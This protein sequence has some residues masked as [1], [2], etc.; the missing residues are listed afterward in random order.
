MRLAGENYGFCDDGVDH[1]NVYTFLKLSYTAPS[2]AKDTGG[3]YTVFTA[4][5][6]NRWEMCFLKQCVGL[7][8]RFI[9]GSKQ[10]VSVC[11]SVPTHFHE[12][13]CLCLG[14]FKDSDGSN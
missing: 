4:H 2:V 10:P 5:C 7:T 12:Y 1:T 9:Y 13:P 14:S 11:M 8:P 3:R 6:G